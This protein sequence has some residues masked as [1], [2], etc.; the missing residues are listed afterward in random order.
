M[1]EV[2]VLGDIG[3]P[4]EDVESILS[5]ILPGFILIGPPGG[6]ASCPSSFGS[7]DYLV[8]AG[9]PITAD[10]IGSSRLRLVCV[11]SGQ[12]RHS[13]DIDAARSSG[14]AVAVTHDPV[15][16]SSAE[17]AVMMTLA[18]LR[19]LIPSHDA[20]TSDA[21]PGPASGRDLRG[22]TVG[23]AGTGAAGMAAARLFSAFGCRLL[24]HDAAER[25]EFRELGGSY[26]NRER[27]FGLSDVVSL[28]RDR[29]GAGWSVDYAELGM[30]KP[31]ALL[32]CTSGAGAVN[33]TALSR[34]LESGTIGGAGMVFDPSELP[35][36]GARILTAPNTVLAAGKDSAT[37]EA[38]VGRVEMTFE[39]MKAFVDG[40]VI[41]RVDVAT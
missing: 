14:T 11:A 38:L 41:N 30:M 19:N 40:R 22:L 10:S 7:L 4:R 1:H 32:V 33:L 15:P 3:L 29:A 23:I 5:R 6:I 17:Q 28:G 37:R 25:R 26:V 18:L 34:A 39:N 16:A 21:P 36:P 12:W 2:L 35:G 24:G 9:V 27:L 13:I 20:V 8:T 31:E